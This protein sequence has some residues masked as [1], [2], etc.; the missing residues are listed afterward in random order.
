[1]ITR[2]NLLTEYPRINQSIL[3][4]PLQQEEFDFIAENMDLADEDDDIG[5]LVDT[6][7][8]K[9]NQVAEKQGAE[10]SPKV[11]TKRTSKVAK[12]KTVKEPKVPKPKKQTSEIEQVAQL[13]I[14]VTFIK[15]FCLLDGKVKTKSQI[16]GMIKRLQKAIAERKIRK[17]STYADA[18]EYIQ[19]HLI[20]DRKSV[21]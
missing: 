13:P 9:L 12:T 11:A 16:H 3:P 7:I 1:M 10:E 18:I 8:E 20:T 17:T 19:N 14:E 6:F 5:K 2:T 4:K 21:V 15:S